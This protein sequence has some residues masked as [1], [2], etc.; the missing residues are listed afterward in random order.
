[1]SFPR[2][3]HDQDFALVWLPDPF[4]HFQKG[5]LSRAVWTQNSH[6]LPS[7]DMQID[8]T[9]SLH[10]FEGFENFTDF[11][12]IRV[13]HL[14]KNYFSLISADLFADFADFF[15]GNLPVFLRKSA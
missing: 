12:G 5:C 10:G 13:Y 15:C 4:D 11:N 1:M 14:R 6:K 7:A 2:F 8:A 9:D 3:A